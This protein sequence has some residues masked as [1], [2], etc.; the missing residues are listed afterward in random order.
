MKKI[1]S[2]MF[3]LVL[4]CSSVYATESSVTELPDE[5]VGYWVSNGCII[6][7]TNDGIRAVAGFYEDVLISEGYCTL[8]ERLIYTIYVAH[9]KRHRAIDLKLTED[10]TKLA[11][12][13]S[14]SFY[15]MKRGARVGNDGDD[16]I[17][18]SFINTW[19]GE[20]FDVTVSSESIKL[21]WH[22]SDSQEYIY[23]ERTI[24][25]TLDSMIW[26]DMKV[27]KIS[28]DDTRLKVE[29]GS[30]VYSLRQGSYGMSFPEVYERT[31]YQN[32]WTD[33]YVGIKIKGDLLTLYSKDVSKV[34][35]ALKIIKGNERGKLFVKVEITENGKVSE[36][37]IWLNYMTPNLHV[38]IQDELYQLNY[39]GYESDVDDAVQCVNEE[40]MKLLEYLFD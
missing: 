37:V 6:E 31:W 16:I 24:D 29:I 1:V 13:G 22:N 15:E 5:M 19:Y 33:G 32:R 20:L 30:D 23:D 11:I 8:N 18:D 36:D 25:T 12:S 10:G 21:S 4:I 28:L 9:N 14:R 40:A 17:L 39:D 7:V 38:R 35:R 34:L 2:L 3:I 27:Y 26:D